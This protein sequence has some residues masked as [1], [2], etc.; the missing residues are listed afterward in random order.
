MPIGPATGFQSRQSRSAGSTTDLFLAR[1][2]VNSFQ[3]RVK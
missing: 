1:S 3:N 2:A